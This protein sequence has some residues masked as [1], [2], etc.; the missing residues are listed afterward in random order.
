MVTVVVAEVEHSVITA[1][2]TAVVEHNSP[3][4]LAVVWMELVA[5]AAVVVTAAIVLAA[6]VAALSDP[7][8]VVAVALAVIAAEEKT[9]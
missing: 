4:A 6:A 3:T 9:P 5:T 8:M 1:F 2:V 7:Y